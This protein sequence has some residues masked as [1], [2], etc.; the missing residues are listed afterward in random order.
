MEPAIT[1]AASRTAA[2]PD[3]DGWIRVT[4]PI[5]S[6]DQAIPELLNSEPTE[7]LAPQELRE[8]IT[9]TLDTMILIYQRRQQP[10]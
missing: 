8:R 9:Q 6:I 7:I 1:Q 2:E 4:I 10:T 3:P 5:E